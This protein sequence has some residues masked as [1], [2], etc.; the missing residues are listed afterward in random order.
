MTK[1]ALLALFATAFLAFGAMAQD[2]TSLPLPD[3]AFKGKIGK[4][5]ADSQQDFP[6]PISAPRAHRMWC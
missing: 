5:F 1:S 2:R 4:T 6:Q 3:P